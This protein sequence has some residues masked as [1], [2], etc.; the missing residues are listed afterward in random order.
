MGSKSWSL[1]LD[2]QTKRV[3]VEHG[4]WSGTTVLR[5]DGVVALKIVPGFGGFADHYAHPS[6]YAIHLGAHELRVRITPARTYDLDLIVDG[7]SVSNGAVIPPLPQPLDDAFYRLGKLGASLAMIAVPYLI[8]ILFIFG[9]YA[10]EWGPRWFA[11]NDLVL[12]T[13]VLP[14]T[15]GLGLWMVNMARLGSLAGRLF[16]GGFGVAS[17]WVAAVSVVDLPG[18]LA[19]VFGQPETRTVTVLASDDNGGKNAPTI[20]TAGGATYQW[21]SSFGLWI[22]PKMTSGTYEIVVTANRHRLV[23]SRPVD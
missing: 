19:D 1:D 2:G 15:A 20:R 17:L 13:G 8:V 14:L 12:A 3:Q 4:Y 22:Y 10:P 23:A 9:R 11:A 5:V 7:R 6:E 18:Q 16:A 21:S